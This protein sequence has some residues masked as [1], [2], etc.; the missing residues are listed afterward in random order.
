MSKE[1]VFQ[2]KVGQDGIGVLKEQVHKHISGNK[3]KITVVFALDSNM[4]LVEPVYEMNGFM[5]GVSDNY[6][7]AP[8]NIATAVSELRK[9]NTPIYY[10]LTKL[11]YICVHNVVTERGKVV[12]NTI[13]IYVPADLNNKKLICDDVTVVFP[14]QS[15]N[16]MADNFLQHTMSRV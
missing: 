14:R 12:K 9:V 10:P 16:V 6:G 11:T 2:L 3:T 8:S 5:V 7:T 15:R 1:K 4:R 13:N